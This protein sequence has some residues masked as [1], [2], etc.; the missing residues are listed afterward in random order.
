MTMTFED[1]IKQ[2]IDV[3]VCDD[4]ED[5]GYPAFTGPLELTDAGRSRFCEILGLPVSID[6]DLAVISLNDAKHWMK[7]Q[8]DLELFLNAAAGYCS[9]SDYNNWFKS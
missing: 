3:D 2:D 1:F 8:R 9:E 7:K 4:V 5:K 6:D